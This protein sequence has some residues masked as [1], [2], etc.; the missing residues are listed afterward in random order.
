MVRKRREK[1][2]DLVCLLAQ[3]HQQHARAESGF[4]IQESLLVIY[5]QLEVYLDKHIAI[6][7]LH[8]TLSNWDL[9]DKRKARLWAC[10]HLHTS[11]SHSFAQCDHT[12]EKR[13]VSS[14]LQLAICAQSCFVEQI[15]ERISENKSWFQRISPTTYLST[16]AVYNWNNQV[17]QFL[18]IHS[19]IKKRNNGA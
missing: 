17:N 19:A 6:D 1:P 12:K 2:C 18:K 10:V 5:A 13:V 7:K 4:H 16:C 3:N 9:F 11:T 15:V 8:A 14:C